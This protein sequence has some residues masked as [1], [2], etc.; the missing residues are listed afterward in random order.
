ML[1]HEIPAGVE[2]TVPVPVP[3]LDT[4]RV[5]DSAAG[6]VAEVGGEGGGGE[7]EAIGEAVLVSAAEPP[8]QPENNEH[9]VKKHARRKI[10]V[11]RWP[12]F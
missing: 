4:A 2:L 3:E 6:G 11:F 12:P 1:P 9:N 5:G 8:P 7:F 10:D